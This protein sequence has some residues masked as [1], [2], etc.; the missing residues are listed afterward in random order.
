MS[1]SC[2]INEGPNKLLKGQ[3]TQITHTKTPWN[4]E[5]F[6][7]KWKIHITYYKLH[8]NISSNTPPCYYTTNIIV[9]C[10]GVEAES[11]DTQTLAHKTKVIP[12]L[13]LLS[14]CTFAAVYCT[15]L[16]LWSGQVNAGSHKQPGT[17]VCYS[18]LPGAWENKK[19]NK[20]IK[21]CVI[22]ADWQQSRTR[23][24]SIQLSTSF[25]SP[26]NVS[27]SCVHTENFACLRQQCDH[28]ITT[29]HCLNLLFM[30][31]KLW[32][33]TETQQLVVQNHYCK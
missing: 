30:F 32:K 2:G 26:G 11:S 17:L 14:V 5:K 22:R 4:T 20:H 24:D 16:Y 27:V 25:S 6:L 28:I 3:F 33:N 1:Y 10:S 19:H 21:H 15:L 8:K 12:D 29:T 18:K 23:I 31:H 9:H 7:F 13:L